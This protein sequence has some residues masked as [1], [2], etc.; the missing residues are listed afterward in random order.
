MLQSKVILE[1]KKIENRFQEQ[2]HLYKKQVH[3]SGDRIAPYIPEHGPVLF[4][5]FYPE[6][7]DEN[8][9]FLKCVVQRGIG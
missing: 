9:L 8:N 3:L 1:K 4:C 6:L 2:T 5:Y 7:K